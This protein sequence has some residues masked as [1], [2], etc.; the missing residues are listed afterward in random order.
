MHPL[1]ERLRGGLIVSCQAGADDGLYGAE[2]MA[3]MARAAE[4]GGAV[5]IRANSPEHIAAVRRVVSL[6]I[7][8]IYKQDLP[9]YGIRITPSL[10]AARELVDAGADI[11]AL[12][13]TYRGPLEGRLP[14]G[15]LIRQVHET[16]GIPV[17]ADI[18]TYEEGVAAAEAGADIVATTLSGYTDYT[19]M[20]TG[21]DFDLIAKLVGRINVPLIAEGRISSP[22]EARRVLE[23]G[24]FAV[25]VGSM[26][27]RPRWIVE[28]YVAALNNYHNAHQGKILA[29]DIGGTKIALGIVEG[30]ARIIYHDSIPTPAQD[31]GQVVVEHL[32]NLIDRAI[33]THSGIQAIGISTTGE[34]DAEG[35]IS[36]ATGFMPGWMGLA[37]GTEIRARFGL[38]VAIENDAQAATLGEA[39]YGAG[40]GHM[41]VL[42]VT[43]GTGVGGGLVVDKRIHTGARGA[44]MA[45][46]HITVERNGRLCTCGRQGCLESYASGTA[47]LADYNARVGRERQVAS[48]QEVMLAAQHGDK[49]AVEAIKI[50]GDWLG[51]GLGLALN[52]IDPSVVVIGGGVSQIGNLFIHSVQ[53]AV[54]RYAYPTVSDTPILSAKLGTQAGLVGAAILAR[55]HLMAL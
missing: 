36:Y 18:S 40:R 2:A 12:D 26:I 45:L 43:A 42:G 22:Q 34:V 53:D 44:A 17:M 16:L 27:T 31:G 9:G 55:Q 54:R 28:Q 21:P 29:V 4:L 1:V 37:L 7:L 47:L 35:K 48:G 30:E 13:A 24:G 5:G 52:L 46:G 3:A 50:M 20:Q 33:K 14:A 41:C 15:E 32:A 10:E 51:Y 11:I 39:L 6:P 23:L 49:D 19:P 25:V 8:G 38:P